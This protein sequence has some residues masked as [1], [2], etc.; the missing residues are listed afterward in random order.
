[1]KQKERLLQS[2]YRNRLKTNFMT[3][4]RKQESPST[5]VVRI[6]SIKFRSSLR[7]MN[8]LIGCSALLCKVNVCSLDMEMV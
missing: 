3:S 5:T 2:I 1:M 8:L 6:L 4:K 7:I